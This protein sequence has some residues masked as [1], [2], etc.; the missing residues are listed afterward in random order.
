MS[1]LRYLNDMGVVLFL[2]MRIINNGLN[3]GSVIIMRAVDKKQD[4]QLE[5]SHRGR[6]K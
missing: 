2:S 4:Y 5:W 3:E 1:T 6:L